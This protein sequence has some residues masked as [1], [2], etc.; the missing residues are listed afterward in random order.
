MCQSYIPNLLK[1]AVKTRCWPLPF[2]PTTW[3]AG[4]LSG[5]CQVNQGN[6]C[7]H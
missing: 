5:D 7:V 3:T 2:V 6:A 4:N 1:Y